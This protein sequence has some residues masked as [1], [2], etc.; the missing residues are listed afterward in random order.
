M[1]QHV[2]HRVQLPRAILDGDVVAEQLGHPHVLWNCC[3]ALVEDELETPMVYAN[4]E[5]VT[6]EIGPP[7]VNHLDQPDELALIGMELGGVGYDSAVEVSHITIALVEHR[8][9]PSP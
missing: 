7:M 9:K 8:T 5:H 3:Q 6:L 4:G 2:C 1:R